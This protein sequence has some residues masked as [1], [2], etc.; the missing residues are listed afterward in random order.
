MKSKW[1]S[2]LACIAAI[3]SIRVFPMPMAQA[4]TFSVIHT[5]TGGADGADPVAGLTLD[6]AGNLYGTASQGGNGGNGTVFKVRSTSGGWIFQRLYAFSGPDGANPAGHLVFG[7]D[8][9]LYGNTEYGGNSCVSG[10]CGTVFKLTP[11]ASFCA[12]LSCPWRETVLYGFVG[13][14]MGLEPMGDLVFDGQG[15]IYG[16]TSMLRGLSCA[17]G[18]LDCG[19]VYELSPT[20][21]GWVHNVLATFLD[22]PG[23]GYYIL[24]DLAGGVVRD[25]AG[26]LYGAVALSPGPPYTPAGYLFKM[27]E[28]SGVWTV[29]M[30]HDFEDGCAPQAGPILDGAGHLY[31]TTPCGGAG[32]GGTVYEVNTDGS[33][34]H[35][36]YGFSGSNGGPD[37]NLVMDS[38]GNLYGATF[39]EG[40]Y[41][42]GSVFELSPSSNGWIYTDLYNFTGGSDGGNPSGSL[43]LDANGNLYGTTTSGGTGYGV[44]WEI[45]P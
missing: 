17:A 42:Y 8:G 18:G 16:T 28:S 9:A 37:D 24:Q 3:V 6:R 25:S 45:T 32:G 1:V 39:S 26:N 20:D 13:G 43:A 4:Q 22:S 23:P 29:N 31:G 40:A 33:D 14:N 41:Q 5:F 38:A 7:P 35:V 34:F 2:L 36:I 21:G 10:G 15:N 12:S 30:I 27:T 11:S 44:V 19:T